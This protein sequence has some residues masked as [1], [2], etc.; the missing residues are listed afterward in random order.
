MIDTVLENLTLQNQDIA[1]PNWHQDLL[2]ERET[3]LKIQ[4]DHFVDWREA[5]KQILRQ[6]ECKSRCSSRSG[7]VTP[8]LTFQITSK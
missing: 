3:T 1:S 8:T 5:K 4:Q 7:F 2:L 6:A